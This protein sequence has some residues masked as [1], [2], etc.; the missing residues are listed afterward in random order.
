MA[1]V[2]QWLS[3]GAGIIAAVMVASKLS[4][5][6][7]GW[8]FVIFALSGVG[9]VVFGIAI[10]ETPLVI[11]NVV[12]VVVN[13]IGVWRYLIVKEREPAAG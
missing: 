9:W 8:G 4:A 13:L 2:I 3:M 12:L 6:V 1:D 7:T 5:K 11:Q 10:G